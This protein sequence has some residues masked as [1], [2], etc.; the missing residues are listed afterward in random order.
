MG[1][2]QLTERKQLQ[3][4]IQGIVFRYSTGSGFWATVFVFDA[5]LKD[6]SSSLTDPVVRFACAPRATRIA[7]FAR[8]GAERLLVDLPRTP[9][10]ARRYVRTLELEPRSAFY[11]E[12]A[13]TLEL[14]PH[15][16][17]KLTRSCQVKR[18]MESER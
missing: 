2:T 12:A 5:G 3:P 8:S 14:R 18:R 6:I 10:Y 9:L 13:L 4:E 16:R 1:P 17:A 15:E 11:K 7:A